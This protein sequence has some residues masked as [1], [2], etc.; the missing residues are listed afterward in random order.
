MRV[1]RIVIVMLLGV[2]GGTGCAGYQQQTLDMFE[3]DK[4][5]QII[6]SGPDTA[7]VIDPVSESCMLIISDIIREAYAAGAVDCQKLKANFPK[8]AEHITW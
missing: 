4:Q 1:A 5:Y 8:A 7:Y 3:G 2:V 6:R